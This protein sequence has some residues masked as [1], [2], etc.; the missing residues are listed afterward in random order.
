MVN[1]IRPTPS[2]PGA[3][4]F[5]VRQM[6]SLRRLGIDVKEFYAD[7]RT[8]LQ[9]I[10]RNIRK[11]N[12]VVNE[13]NPDI[14]HA[15]Y[16]SVTAL[17]SVIMRRCRVVVSFCGSDLLGSPN[18]PKWRSLGGVLCSQ[19]AA[20]CADEVICK[21]EGLRRRLWIRKHSVHIIPNGVDLKLFRAIPRESARRY[22]GWPESDLIVFFNSGGNDPVKRV[23]LAR[24]AIE[25]AGE[26][27]P[28]IRLFV[29]GN[30]T[31]DDMPWMLNAS[32]CLLLT[33]DHEGSPNIIKE[34]LAC[35][36]PIVSVDV[37]DVVERLKGVTP[38]LVVDRDPKRLGHA[39]GDILREK[40]RSNGRNIIEKVLS[41][42][43]IARRLYDL[44]DA[45]CTHSG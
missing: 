14:V 8:S 22:L 19:I 45:V 28:M 10:V 25:C 35:N 3:G 27:L 26:H 38:S 12:D 29:A 30:F 2:N 15:Q 34:A 44:Y 9:G 4:V 11:V 20:I 5:I 13:I 39:I 33:S 32:D 43:A 21:S 1:S 24:R 31:P 6:A 41:E 18:I 37:G 23:D 40:R 17:M 7:D 16:G 42:E 36:L